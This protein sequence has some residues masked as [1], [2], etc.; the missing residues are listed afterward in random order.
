MMTLV[1][2]NP[3]PDVREMQNEMTRFINDFFRSR[4][5]GKAGGTIASWTPAV[6]MYETAEALTLKADLPGFSKDDVQIEI[7][8]GVLTLKGERKRAPDV[9]GERYYRTER[10]YGAFQRAFRLPAIVDAEKT[11]ACFKNGVLEIKLA[12]TEKAKAKTITVTA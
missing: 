4:N 11:E 6:E 10:A 3:V 2:W 12:K 8:D 7:Q 1:R 9:R 5:D